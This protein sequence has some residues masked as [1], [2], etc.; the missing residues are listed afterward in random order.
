[1]RALL[2]AGG[3]LAAPAW[4]SSAPCLEKVR[5]NASSAQVEAACGKPASVRRETMRLRKTEGA[6]QQVPIELWTYPGDPPVELTF[7][8]GRLVK[9]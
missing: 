6:C 2:A 5:L 8:D 3:L 1:M 7:R 9:K 4:A